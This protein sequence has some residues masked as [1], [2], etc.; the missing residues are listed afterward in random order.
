MAYGRRAAEYI[1][2]F[3]SV[4]SIPTVYRDLIE[5][6]GRA[7]DGPAIDVGCGPGQWTALLHELGVDVRGV[8]PVPEFV[9]DARVRFPHLRFDLGEA[10]AL[11]VDDAGLGGILAWYS[12]IHV[13]PERVGEVLAEFARVLR[14]GGSLLVGFFTGE[15]LI[16]FD[17]AVTPA[18]FW[19]VDDLR[20]VVE[21]A[22]FTVTSTRTR[23]DPPARPHGDLIAHRARQSY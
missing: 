1:A 5:A 16:E 19:P 12:L 7:V 20:A 3:G 21:D 10:A 13:R 11:D 15:E 4:D 18:Y 14:P 2:R 6:W 8:D 9:A 23:T 22:G 17:H